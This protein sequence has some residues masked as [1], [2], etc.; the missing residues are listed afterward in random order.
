[1]RKTIKSLVTISPPARDGA[2]L[3]GGFDFALFSSPR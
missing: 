3:A 1:M 2:W